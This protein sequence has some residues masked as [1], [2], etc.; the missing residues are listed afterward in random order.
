MKAILPALK[1]KKRYL[2]FKVRSAK[3]IG[4][5]PALDAIMSSVK[6]FLGQLSM[7][8]AGIIMLTG[9]WDNPTQTGIIKV[10]HKF[11]NDLRTA[12]A[13]VKTISGQQVIIQTIAVSGILKKA[14]KGR[15]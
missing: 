5:K 11:V 6:D 15:C 9:K 10:G 4:M 12:L 1:E 2:V 7:A 3:E 14:D 8:R 13:F